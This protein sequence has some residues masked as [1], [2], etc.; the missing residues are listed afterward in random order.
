MV[1]RRDCAE[2]THRAQGV[3]RWYPQRLRQIVHELAGRPRPVLRLGCHRP[4]EH[5]RRGRGRPRPR[6]GQIGR[7]AVAR[8]ERHLHRRPAAPRLLAAQR[9]ER[10]RAKGVYVTRGRARAALELLGRHIGRGAHD[11]PGAGEPR[12]LTQERDPEV[13]QPRA[14]VLAKQDIRRLDVAMDHPLCVRRVQ[15]RRHGPQHGDRLLRRQAAA[16]PQP[17][18]KI[19]PLDVFHDQRDAL[20]EFEHVVDRHDARV[21]EGRADLRL[22]QEPHIGVGFVGD[23]QE[24]YRNLTPEALVLRL[25]HRPHPAHTHPAQQAVTIG[26]VAQWHFLLDVRPPRK[27]TPGIFA[28]AT[29]TA[30]VARTRDRRFRSMSPPRRRP[31]GWL[32]SGATVAPDLRSWPRRG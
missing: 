32:I 27:E 17:L 28:Q 7:S 12:P 31:A 3:G 13:G 25:P 26:D 24:L 18:A 8:L 10:H 16:C 5:L 20:V 22:A 1:A 29:A 19:L 9:L 23:V 11:H 2:P 14:T 30:H 4:L 6:R 15:R 21:A